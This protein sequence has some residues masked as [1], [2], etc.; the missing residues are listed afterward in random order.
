MWRG[1]C[2]PARTRLRSAF[3][4]P[5]HPGIAHEESIAAGAGPNGG[6]QALDGPTFFASEGWDWIPG[7]RDRNIGLWQGVRLE[8]SGPVRIGDP[9]I[10]TTLPKGDASEALVELDIPLKNTTGRT[11]ATEVSA[12]FDDVSVR[13]TVTVPPGGITIRPRAL[14]AKPKLWWPNGY[15]APTLHTA[16]L[17]VRA[18]GAESDRRD[19]RFGIRQI[20]YELSLMDPAGHLRR[21]EG[22]LRP[23]PR[24]RPADHRRTAR[25][26]PSQRGHDGGTRPAR[27]S[28]RAGGS[29][30]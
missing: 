7:V 19:V 26:G 15:G 14:V 6:M 16:R 12:G 4:R 25:G 22:R 8:D 21:V 27:A 23:R 17:I 28:C 24:A 1:G 13:E 29:I 18:G 5:P 10:V 3:R 30:H 9:Q 11:V 20:T 2:G